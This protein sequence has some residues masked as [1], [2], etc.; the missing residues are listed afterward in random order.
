[1]RAALV[2]V[3]AA[4]AL[5]GCGAP[6][7]LS[8]E[9]GRSLLT[10]RERLDD[11]IDTEEVLRTSRAEAR[12]L[13]RRVRT[14]ISDGSFESSRL[15]EFGIARL[16]LLR[17]AVPSL[18]VVNARGTARALD[19]PATAA[20]LRHAESDAA[21]AMLRPARDQVDVIVKTLED[22]DAGE[23]TRIP[24]GDRTAAAYL[25]EAERDVRPIWPPLAARLRG[26]RDDL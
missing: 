13:T 8:E 21:R 23:E 17:D 6:E 14:L 7:E 10:A 15:D 11:A 25:R 12:R 18:V 22:G 24:P 4:L 19:R 9:D 16:G 26:A 2:A 5:S 20:F 1:V 3:A